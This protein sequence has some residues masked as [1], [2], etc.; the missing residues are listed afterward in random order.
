MRY[1]IKD[2]ATVELLEHEGHLVVDLLIADDIV[3]ATLAPSARLGDLVAQGRGF[4]YLRGVDQRGLRFRKG[5]LFG[6]RN[7]SVIWTE[8]GN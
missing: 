2:K 3:T 6:Y 7:V 1:S 8:R 4:Y 5:V